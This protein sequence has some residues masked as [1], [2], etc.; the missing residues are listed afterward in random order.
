MV[1]AA[2]GM[3]GAAIAV[4]TSEP[5]SGG[6]SAETGSQDA[7]PTALDGEA[8][9]TGRTTAEVA[10]RSASAFRNP[11]SLTTSNPVTSSGAQGPSC[12]P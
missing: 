2:S 8:P 3:T 6:L 5:K 10:L 9:G 12:V 1:S 4:A 11:L 7:S